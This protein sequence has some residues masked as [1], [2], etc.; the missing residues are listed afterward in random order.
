MGTPLLQAL[1]RQKTE[2]T[3]EFFVVLETVAAGDRVDAIRLLNHIHVVD[4]IFSAHL[5]GEP[6]GYKATNTPETPTLDALRA[7]TLDMNR[8]FVEQVGA[9]APAQLAESVDFTFTDGQ[10]GRMS[11]EEMLAHVITHGS[12][13]RGEV[14]QM[15]KRLSVAPPRDLFTAH[16]HRAEPQ[17]RIAA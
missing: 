15:L 8:W 17:R 9:L 1:F 5:R 13:H 2:I 4:R 7:A 16:L 11:R 6:H 12:Y 10:R 14:G 3:E